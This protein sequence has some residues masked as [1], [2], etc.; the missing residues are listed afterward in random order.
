VC[1]TRGGYRS[2]TENARSA[3]SNAIEM[4]SRWHYPSSRQLFPR[5]GHGSITTLKII[6]R[7]KRAS[8]GPGASAIKE[9]VFR[10]FL[11]L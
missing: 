3:K 2:E 10:T 4:E 9:R 7:K 5:N 1:K 11:N 6:P 8:K